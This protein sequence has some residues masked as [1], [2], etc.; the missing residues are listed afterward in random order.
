MQIFPRKKSARR[1]DVGLRLCGEAI[2]SLALISI[3]VVPSARGDELKSEEAKLLRNEAAR[4]DHLSVARLSQ[5]DEAALQSTAPNG[6]VAQRVLVKLKHGTRAE[7]SDR[8][9]G[10]VLGARA[11]DE[12]SPIG[13]RVIELSENAETVAQLYALRASPHVE[14]AELDRIYEPADVTPNDYWYF[15]QW[16]L[17]KIAAPAAWSTTTGASNV[18]I[19]I[20]DTGVEASHPDLSP[21]LMA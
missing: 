1:Q 19:A 11:I 20:C 12:I 8:V 4:G 3:T 15:G 6:F 2:A 9:M 5:E 21:K 14:Y 18:I 17:T 13:V 10:H 7:D 16:H